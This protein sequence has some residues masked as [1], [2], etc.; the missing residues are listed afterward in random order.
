MC[1]NGGPVMAAM[2]SPGD[3]IFC[4]GWSG[5]TECSAADSLG[6]PILG[7]TS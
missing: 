2:H 6:G 7:G 3:H 4:H 5:G 1:C